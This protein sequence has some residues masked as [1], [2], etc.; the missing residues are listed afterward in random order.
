[1]VRHIYAP[2]LAICTYVIIVAV[3]P[4]IMRSRPAFSLRNVMA[5]YNSIAVVISGYILVKVSL[6][7]ENMYVMVI[8]VFISNRSFNGPQMRT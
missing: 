2:L 1:M 4:R 5:A 7:L 8:Q 6:T 3:G